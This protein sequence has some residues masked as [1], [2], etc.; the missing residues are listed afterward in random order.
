MYVYIYIYGDLDPQKVQGWGNDHT[1]I[2]ADLCGACWMVSGD[3]GAFLPYS[4][5]T[6]GGI[7]G[8]RPDI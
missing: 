8:G 6:G 1:P 3:G 7:R 5:K 4:H 2:S